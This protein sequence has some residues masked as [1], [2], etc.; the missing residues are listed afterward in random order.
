MTTL[1]EAL[2]AVLLSIGQPADP[3]HALEARRPS[4]ARGSRSS[5]DD[6][7]PEYQPAA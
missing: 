5:T 4:G 3:S 2:S 7:P 6:E 1:I